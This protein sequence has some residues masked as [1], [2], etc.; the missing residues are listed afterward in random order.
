M[1]EDYEIG[2]FNLL[3]EFF[4]DCAEA[5]DL[6]ALLK[7]AGGRARWL[8]EFERFTLALTGPTD[9]AY[10]TVT[11]DGERLEQVASGA[12]PSAHR[13]MIGTALLRGTPCTH[14]P[15][16]SGLCHPLNAQGRQIGAICFSDSRTA[17]GYRDA[18]LIHYLAQFLAGTLARLQ[19]AATIQ[20]QSAELAAANRAK[21]E[22]LAILGH[23]LRNPLAPIV[24][25]VEILIRRAGDSAPREVLMIKRQAEHV[26]RLVDD[27]LD[28]SRLTNGKLEL[29]LAPVEIASVVARAI[30]LAGPLIEQRQ[31]RLEV[32]VPLT[33]LLVSGDESRLQQ[34]FANLLTN[35]ARYME[36][37]GQVLIVARRGDHEIVVDVI[38][39]GSGISPKLVP[40]L[41]EMFVQGSRS[42]DR[43]QG[44]L[45]LGLAIVKSLIE[46]HGGSVSVKSEW[47]NRGTTFTIRLPSL[48]QSIAPVAVQPT[49]AVAVRSRRVLIVD[50]NEDAATLMANL[51]EAA[52]HHV[53]VR[54]DGVETLA[55]LEHFRPEVALL[56]IG[57]PDMDGYELAG[58]IRSRLG[59][60]TPFLIALT[61][62][63]RPEDHQ[64]SRA[65]GFNVHLVKPVGGAKLLQAVDAA[66]NAA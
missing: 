53:V 17:Y 22:F 26:V 44:G 63:G 10:W 38:D 32:D 60:A 33:G 56:D 12:L 48:A 9:C 58:V 20:Q 1:S 40:R 30:E 31:H 7:A 6:G 66:P 59:R 4:S 47:P 25:A 2:R 28:V 51:L 35:A 45:G 18:R 46:L 50:D 52:G 21:D 24:T 61:G 54:H 5:N 36:P 62:Y 8:L 11:R 27:L 41:F 39:E 57:L 34:V 65:A 19:Q 64:R 16:I 13:S 43:S 15:P 29:A 55:G 23:E 3:L 14:E 37:G 49:C 42:T